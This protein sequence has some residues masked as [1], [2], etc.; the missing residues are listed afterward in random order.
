MV[1][2]SLQ[3]QRR[4]TVQSGTDLEQSRGKPRSRRRRGASISTDEHDEQLLVVRFG[5]R[6]VVTDDVFVLAVLDEHE[7][8]LAGDRPSPSFRCYFNDSLAPPHV[9][10]FIKKLVVS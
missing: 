3:D 2:A 9:A 5:R 8:D 1:Q 7:H 4:G 6:G 10:Q